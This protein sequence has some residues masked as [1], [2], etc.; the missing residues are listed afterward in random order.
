MHL[1]VYP[2]CA[3]IIFQTEGEGD[4]GRGEEE[5]GEEE[6]GEEGRGEGRVEEG[7]GGGEAL[8]FNITAPT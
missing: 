5:R 7:W 2:L 1:V 3:G 6:R 8:G 4:G